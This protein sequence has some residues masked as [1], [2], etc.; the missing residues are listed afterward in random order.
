[1]L[2][3]MGF[4]STPEQLSMLF[5]KKHGMIVALIYQ[6]AHGNNT[7]VFVSDAC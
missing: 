2:A 6:Q 7:D 4:V 1:M 3:D 5:E